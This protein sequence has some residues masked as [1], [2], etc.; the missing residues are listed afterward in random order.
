MNSRHRI[1]AEAAGGFTTMRTTPTHSPRAA[2]RFATLISTVL[3][4]GLIQTVPGAVDAVAAGPPTVHSQEKPVKGI[5]A[6]PKPRKADTTV[7]APAKPKA[8]WPTAASAEVVLPSAGAGPARSA[9]SASPDGKGTTASL[10]VTLTPLSRGPVAPGKPALAQPAIKDTAATVRVLDRKTAE[11]AGVDGVLLTISGN[12]GPAGKAKVSV[13]YSAFANA[14]GAGYGERL[15]LVQLPACVLTTP[16][17]PGCRTETP[18]AGRN[19]AENRRVV[20]DAVTVPGAGARSGT[21]SFAAS[22]GAQQAVGGMTVLAAAPAAAGPSGDF[23]ASPLSSASTWNTSLNSGSFTWSYGMAAPPVPT[24][25]AP[26]LALSYSSGSVDGRTSNANSQASWAGDGFGFAP[27]FVERSYKP[28]ADDG[29]K[30]DAG[31]PGD[32]CWAYDNATVSFAG[33]SGQLIPVGTNEWRIKGDDGTKVIRGYNTALNNGD[34]DGEY[35]EAVIPDGTRYYFGYNRLPQWK[36]GLPE[37][38]SVETVPV[39]GNNSGEPCNKS[40]YTDS[41]CQQ[42]W[43]WN[44]DVVIDAE[45]N[46]I[47]YWYNQ[48]TN[49]YGRNLK[50]ADDTPYVRGATLDH[51]EYGQ[52][53]ADIYSSSVKPM[54][55]VDFTTAERCLESD[56]TLCD[57]A[58]IDTNQQYWYDTPWDQ[59]CKAGTT[60]DQG[61]YAPTFFSRKRLTKVTTQTLQPGGSYKPVDEWTLHHKWGTADGDY[62]LLLDSIQ[63]TALAGATPVKLAPTSLSYDTRIG[64]LDKTGD[65]RLPYYKQRLSTIIDE[66]GSQ[67]DVNYSQPAC[68]WN[69]LPT[70]QS[71]TTHC[72]PQ[73]YQPNNDV[74]MTTEWFNKYV[75]DSVIATDRTGGAPDMVTH[76]T[77]LDGGAWAYDDDEGITKEKLK[78]WSQ[79]RGHAHV[80]VETGGVSGMSTQADHYFLRGMNGDR[81]DLSDKSKLRSVTVADGE[82]TTLTDDDAWA[83]FEYRNETFDKP[84]GKVLAKSVST[85]WKKETAKRVRDWGTTTADL[86]GVSVSRAFTSLDAGAGAQWGETRTNTTFDDRGRPRTTEELGDTDVAG[87]DKC[88]T[89]T[90]ADNTSSW[91]LTGVIRTETVAAKC[92]ATPNK[93][94]QPDGTSLVLADTRTRYDDQAY[95]VAPVAGRPTMVETLKARNGSAATYLDSTSTYDGYGRPLTSTAL[96]S[97]SVYD[98][99]DESKAPTTTV[100]AGARTTTTSYSPATGRPSSAKTVT[101]PATVGTAA[102]AQTT[103][104]YYDT[105]RGLPGTTVD[106]TG[107]R[108]DVLY[109]ALGRPLK[110]WQPDRSQL[111]GIDGVTPNLEFRYSDETAPIQSVATLSLNNDGSQDT[112]YTLYDSF[113]RPRQTQGPGVNGGR[114]LT[115]TFYDE[116]GQNTLNHAAYYNTSAPSSALFNVVDADGVETQTATEYDGL[117]RATKST[118]LK[119]NGVGT[120]LATTTT[121]YG[122]DRITVTPPKGATPITTIV[123]A[124]GRTT[125]LRQYQGGSQTGPL[126]P[127]DSTT[128]TYDPAG[129]QNK[130]TGP[131]GSVWTWIYD[132]RGRQ[133]K[134]VD[135]DSGTTTK[136]YSD[137]GDLVSSTDGRGKTVTHVYDNLSRELETHDGGAT[138]PLLTSQTWDPANNQGQMASSTRYV[139]VGGTTYAYKSVINAY[140]AL[141]RPTKATLTVPS[142]PGQEGLAGSYASGSSYNLDGTVKATSYPAAGRLASESLAFTYNKLHQLVSVGSNLSTYLTGQ[143]YSLTGKPLQTTL[144]AGAKS[145]WITNAYEEGTQ[146]LQSSRTDQQDITGAARADVYTYDEAG[147]VTSVSDVSR[148][149]TDRQCFQYDYLARLT[150]AYTPSATS[151]PDSPVGSALGGVAP[152][153][154]SYTY[155]TDGTR[156]TETQHDPAGATAKD[157]SVSYAYAGAGAAQRHSLLATSTLTGGTGTPV[158]ETYAYD[159]AG[160]TIERHLNPNSGL[161]DDQ[162][163]TWDS[164]GRLGHVDDTVRTK[165]GS[166]T[167][168]TKKGTDYVYDAS[169]GRLTAHSADTA[170]PSAENTT[171]YLGSTELNLVK[172]AAKPTSTRYYSL[173]DATAVRTDDSKV[174]FQVADPHGTSDTSIGAADGAMTER[175]TTP[176]G[177]DRGTPPSSW[178]GTKGFVGGTKDV[179]TGLTHLGAREYDPALGRFISVDPVLAPQDP[180][181]LNGYAYSNNNPTTLSDPTGLRPDGACGGASS[182]C[183]TGD[184]KIQVESWTKDEGTWTVHYKT[185]KH[186]ILPGGVSVSGV[187]NFK[188][189][190]DLTMKKLAVQSKH[191]D[192][193]R[194]SVGDFHEYVAA[195][196]NACSEI[197]E[198][199]DSGTYDELFSKLRQWELDNI[200]IF[201]APEGDSFL[202]RTTGSGR[203]KIANGIKKAGRPSVAAETEEESIRVAPGGC[204]NSFPGTT[205]VLLADGST[206]AIDEL[207]LGDEVAATDPE[208]G[209]TGARKVDATILTPNDTDFTTLT[210]GDPATASSSITAT[211]HHPFWSPSAH[212]WVD[213]GDLK[214]GMTVRSFAGKQLKIAAVKR[215]T[216]LQAAYNLTVRG[217]HTYYVLAGETPVLVH[218]SRGN[219]CPHPDA[220]GP[221]TSFRRDGTTGEIDHYE[222]YDRP[223]DPRDPRPFIPTKRVDVK[224]KPHYD[225][226]TKT[227]IPTPH[228]NLPDGSAIPAEPWEIPRRNP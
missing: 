109:D 12:D 116:R 79:W 44:L 211:D 108:T 96:A 204:A 21:Q 55:R 53:Q 228:V 187:K 150:E 177:E 118:V 166:S 59:N 145:T 23:K 180:Q 173:G 103:T 92:S 169:G 128:Y 215:F 168:T 140:D 73:L 52:Q 34:N 214:P 134:A 135:P 81:T 199:R 196:V 223:S 54:A 60:C 75:V 205:K 195:A 216:K 114:I 64:R 127:Y 142:V 26:E 9:L 183:Q 61:R 37:T 30:N 49:S 47:T 194:D 149:G 171:L 97:T 48:E 110:V 153:W 122:G 221:H 151:C 198:C 119:G 5:N 80:R 133:V 125:E 123:D 38:K 2:G 139:A 69:S 101:P 178:A 50:S 182:T 70:P 209:E 147:N 156:K 106:T 159:A 217:V 157:K 162:V 176:F 11:K 167:V 154:S 200:P 188:K 212:A 98:V 36:A 146:R 43:R 202:G 71:N 197:S 3:V 99:T 28:C 24:G 90:Y 105:L 220:E 56:T 206:K 74:P 163:L 130:L 160:N 172:G 224:G 136:T 112:G 41:W 85:P 158:A 14:A 40:A 10:P 113:G 18:L 29:V 25:L 15:R 201:G 1:A 189:L 185:S 95:G 100:L 51:I 62:Q 191:V 72:F 89:T 46:D 86:T 68:D 42:G 87:D 144:N 45:G 225:K 67:L 104:T 218:N 164:E 138:G 179:S 13:D 148:T 7:S 207:Q 181:S 152:Y 4:A 132:Q 27:G 31:Q 39:Y 126:G 143:T 77:Y 66:S 174:T 32:L 76:Y 6:K 226:Q 137:F 82:G 155:N 117:G 88:T 102:S 213:A 57:P 33:H 111:S 210:V 22:A 8:T 222:S 121:Q 124:S 16:D 141:Y 129:H 63:H 186:T 93:D 115:D 227:R 78:S 19:D 219:L 193:G 120:P 175:R 192:F 190:R 17:K 65:G 58:K 170:N 83:G 20:A 35:F 107:R 208:K 203:A 184:G 91:I 161:A 94:T 84:G 131:D 165:S